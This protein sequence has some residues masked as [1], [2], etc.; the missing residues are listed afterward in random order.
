KRAYRTGTQFRN[1]VS[2]SGGT[3]KGVFAAS[4]SSLNQD[5]VI[6]FSDYSNYSAKVNGQL[7]FNNKFKMGA[8]VN[9]IKSGGNRVNADRYGEQ[10]IYWSPRWD[11]K[12]YIKADGTQNTYGPDNDNPIYTLATNRFVD[13][14]NRV[15]ASAN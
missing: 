9:Y 7:N 1:T 5:G 2:M 14:V 12:D 11:V 10:L 13:D 4:F 15:I 3:E 6:P 8:S